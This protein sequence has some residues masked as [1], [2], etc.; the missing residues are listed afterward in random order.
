ML[1]QAHTVV[2][3]QLT[4]TREQAA[5]ASGEIPRSNAP[6]QDAAMVRTSFRT[7]M[8]PKANRPS[9]PLSLSVVCGAMPHEA[10]ALNAHMCTTC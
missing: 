9:P 1:L 4:T 7:C 8:P 6:P 3:D 2:R 10:S 5:V